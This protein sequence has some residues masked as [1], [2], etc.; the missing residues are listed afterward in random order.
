M[1]LAVGLAG[2]AG[3]V[4]LTTPSLTTLVVYSYDSLLGGG[5]GSND[6]AVHDSVFGSFERAHHVHIELACPGGTLVGTLAAEANAPSADV[7]IGLDEITGPQAVAQGLLAPFDPGDGSDW[8]PGVANVLGAPGYLAP[9]E[10][11]YLAIDY[12]ASFYDAT[13]GAVA[14]WSFPATA[15]NHSWAT[16]L[17]IENPTTDIT[18]EEFLLW[19]VSF[20]SQV[21]H[22]PWQGFW[23]SVDPYAPIVPDWGTGYGSF[24]STSGN[25]PMF[26]S[27]ST[28]PASN[29]Y[30]QGPA[31]NATVGRWNGTSYGWET[32]YG[33]GVVHGCPH[34]GLAG[35]FERWFGSGTVQANLPETEWEYPANASVALPTEFGLAVPPGSIV[36]LDA[37]GAGGLVADLPQYLSGWQDIANQ[38][39]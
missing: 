31:F 7:V 9:Y 5:C 32:V 39:G 3:Y 25:P 10:Y 6:T 24:L 2:Y 28:D 33:I 30:Y 19:E 37:Q 20:Y 11:G 26:V 36:P 15:A 13:Q 21:L 29:W 14:N 27:Y 4:S 8:V 1:A 12:N 35:D 34:P 22:Q 38:V 17:I 18:G 16:G 23:R